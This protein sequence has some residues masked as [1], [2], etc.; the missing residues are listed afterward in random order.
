[1]IAHVP[2]S[3]EAVEE[4]LAG[5][6]LYRELAALESDKRDALSVARCVR[7]F[8]LGLEK[9]FKATVAA[10]DPYLLLSK[11]DHQLLTQL[12]RDMIGRPVPSIF[13]SRQPL[14]TLN[15]YQT[16]DS[17]ETSTRLTSM[18]PYWPTLTGHS[19]GSLRCGTAHSMGN[20]MRIWMRW[21]RS[22]NSFWPGS[23][24]WWVP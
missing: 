11:P 21:W 9:G 12:R 16:G 1:M 4:F 17:Y 15:M 5:F 8:Y 14:D 23:E 10:V 18:S 7:T 3:R 22:W 2:F 19:I 13:C 20:S 6:A 24:R